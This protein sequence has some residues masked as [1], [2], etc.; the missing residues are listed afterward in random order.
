MDLRRVQ[1]RL[2]NTYLDAI[3]V[4]VLVSDSG[5]KVLLEMWVTPVSIQSLTSLAWLL[6][7]TVKCETFTNLEVWTAS[8]YELCPVRL[9]SKAC[10]PDSPSSRCAGGCR[11]RGGWAWGLGLCG[12][13]GGV[14][15]LRQTYVAKVDLDEFQNLLLLPPSAG[16]RFAS[17]PGCIEFPC[18][19][20]FSHG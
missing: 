5:D 11:E 9:A 7:S 16:L 3:G 8:L 15:F 20:L 1:T 12:G 19:R 18:S 6:R 4:H 17:T 14:L 10:F 2:V 13:W